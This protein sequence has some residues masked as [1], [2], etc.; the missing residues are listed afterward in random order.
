VSDAAH[1]PTTSWARRARGRAGVLPGFGISLG[2]TTAYLGL[3]VLIPL[4]G[5][6]WH[7]AGLGAEGLWRKLA[8]PRVGAA[9]T[10]TFGVS[11]LAALVN[12]VFGV[13]AAWVLVRYRFPGRRL[14]DALID[15]PFALPT[16][17]AGI[18]LAALFA[19]N[20]W[21]GQWIDPQGVGFGPRPEDPAL[22]HWYDHLRFAVNYSRIGIAI[23]LTFIGLPFVVR[24]VQP[25]LEE[26]SKETEEAAAC[27]GA[28]RWQTVR[29][30]I[31]P[32]L[33]PAVL[34]GFA[35][36]FARAIGEYGSVVFISGNRQWKPGMDT[37][38]TEI[39]PHLIIIRLE[40]Y[41]YAGAIAL[42]TAM[43]VASFALLL[44]VNLLQRWAER[45]AG[46]AS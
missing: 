41:D 39:V 37:G 28:T 14:L 44:L 24:T 3:L 22:W 35:L 33:L 21:L 17:V 36:S 40:Q 30:V 1:V 7:S 32:E 27:L 18:S 31:F 20:G 9:F 16:A 12:L 4:A 23:A 5:L 29:R 6:F 13:L 46:G 8:T 2:Y 15:L 19:P 11:F 42:G 45:R 10:V 38:S 25:V 34:T 43:L 26:L